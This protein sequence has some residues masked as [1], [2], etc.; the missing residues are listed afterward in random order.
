M[1]KEFITNLQQ[2]GHVRA[3][4]KRLNAMSKTEISSFYGDM[5]ASTIKEQDDRSRNLIS[6][7]ESIKIFKDLYEQITCDV[8]LWRH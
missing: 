6:N 8:P 3:K 2:V 5:G 7:N 4:Q 1:P